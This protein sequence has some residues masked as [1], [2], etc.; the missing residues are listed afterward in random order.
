MIYLQALPQAESAGFIQLAFFALIIFFLCFLLIR[1]KNYLKI[2]KNERFKWV[3]GFILGFAYVSGISAY[4]TYFF[5]DIKG[6]KQLKNSWTFWDAIVTIFGVVLYYFH[7]FKIKYIIKNYKTIISNNEI[8]Q[9]FLF[10]LFIII[11]FSG[12]K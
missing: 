3:V 7:F 5:P 8:L 11:M 9:W 12:G 10:V 1:N 2:I 4:V 6:F